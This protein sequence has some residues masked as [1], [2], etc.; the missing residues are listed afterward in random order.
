VDQSW[1]Y[2]FW[3]L[4]RTSTFTLPFVPQY[5]RAGNYDN[6]TISLNATHQQSGIQQ[7][8]SHN[9]NAHAMMK[10]TY[11]AVS[12]LSDDRPFI[13]TRGSFASTGQYASQ[14]L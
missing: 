14:G 4:N 13:I 1:F 2:S 3:P 9:L 5:Q 11:K 7:Y 12:N 6:W 8:D 10:A